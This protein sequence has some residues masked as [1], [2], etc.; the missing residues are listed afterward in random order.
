MSGLLHLKFDSEA[1]PSSPAAK[2]AGSVAPNIK[3][4]I[5]T[6]SSIC[7][8]SPLWYVSVRTAPATSSGAASHCGKKDLGL[9]SQTRKT[10][11]APARKNTTSTHLS[12]SSLTCGPSSDRHWPEGNSAW[13]K[14]RPH[15]PGPLACECSSPVNRTG[16]GRFRYRTCEIWSMEHLHCRSNEV[17]QDFTVAPNAGTKPDFPEEWNADAR[18]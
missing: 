15:C 1:L 14:M 5:P 11:R 3:I 8:T 18:M 9:L 2:K 17:V 10:V 4:G 13:S 6:Q 12:K 7:I 16:V